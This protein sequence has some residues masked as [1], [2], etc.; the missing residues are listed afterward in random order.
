[1]D[2]VQKE[3]RQLYSMMQTGQSTSF[4]SQAVRPPLN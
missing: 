2:T 4:L 3:T 1:M